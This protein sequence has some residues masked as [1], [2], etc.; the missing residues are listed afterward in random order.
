MITL[1]HKENENEMKT[2]LLIGL[3]LYKAK[4]FSQALLIFITAAATVPI[5]ETIKKYVIPNLFDNWI[6]FLILLLLDVMSGV[7]KHSGLWEKNGKNTLDKDEFFF[8]LFRK[9]FIGAVWLVLINVIYNL[10][11][12]S[13]YFDSFGVGVLI[14]WLGWSISSNLYVISGSTFPP[15]WVMDKFRKA[16]EGDEL[17]SK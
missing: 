12:S 11:N 7:L 8:K 14:S 3:F 2:F 10:D 1:S 15:K 16:N 9:V 5:L 13:D 6:I 17:P 4:G